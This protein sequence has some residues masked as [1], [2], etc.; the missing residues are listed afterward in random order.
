MDE[1]MNARVDG[2][3]DGWVSGL[4]DSETNTAEEQTDLRSLG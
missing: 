3:M 1:W 2:W 4:A